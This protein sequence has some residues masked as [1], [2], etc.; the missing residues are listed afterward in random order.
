MEM[1]CK[2]RGIT[3]IKMTEICLK[4]NGIPNHH[5]QECSLFPSISGKRSELKWSIFKCLTERSLGHDAIIV[6]S[7]NPEK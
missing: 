2:I 7:S 5:D 4:A 1:H 3:Y 6:L